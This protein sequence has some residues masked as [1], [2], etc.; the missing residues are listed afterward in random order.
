VTTTASDLVYPFDERP[1]PGEA[2]QVA[3]GVLWIRLKVPILARHVNLWALE[4][5][6]GWTIVDTGVHDEPTIATWRSLLKGPLGGRPIKRVLVT[7]MHRDHSGM[8]GCLTRQFDCSLWMTRLEY[9]ECHVARTNGLAPITE[10]FLNFYRSAGWSDE[11]L[12]RVE[13]RHDAFSAQICPLPANYRRIR[14]GDRIDIGGREWIVIVGTGHTAEHA[15]LHCPELNIFISGD[16][17]LPRISSNIS[18]LPLEPEANPVADWYASLAKLRDEVP[19]D[20]LVLPSHN[21]CFFG[22]HRRL[23]QL[24]RHMHQAIDRLRQRLAQPA[25]IMDC[26]EPLFGRAIDE[27]NAALVVVATGEA[28]AC[29]NFIMQSGGAV[30]HFDADGVAWYE[31]TSHEG[32]QPLS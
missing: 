31:A 4:D 6:N 28:V 7:H 26:M 25:R 13:E 20:V 16:Q 27:S 8:A 24:T 22:V 2:M 23:E 5:G 3:P 10:Q 9:L 21:E 18:V 11:A 15:C 32:T 1:E 30:R 17:V 19:A 29:L 12:E 14:H